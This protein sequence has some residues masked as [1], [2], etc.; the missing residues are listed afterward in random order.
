MDLF[1]AAGIRVYGVSYDAQPLLTK[2][3]TDY[4]IGYDLLSDEGSAVIRE[5]GILNTTIEPDS[6]D[7][8]PQT[9]QTFYGIPF[10]GVY[11]VDEQGVVSDKFFHRHYA[12]RESAGSIRDSA[13]GEILARHEV[14][15][16][17]LSDDHL[18][19]SVFLADED[20]EFETTSTIYVRFELA[21]GFHIY[22]AP[23]PEGYVATTVTLPETKGVRFGEAVYPPTHERDFPE[24]G[25][26]LNVY[27][28]VTDIAIPVALNAEILN[29]T[30]AEKP[31]EIELPLS[32]TY[33]AC[34]ETVCYRPRT[35]T[36]MLNVAIQPLVMPGAPRQGR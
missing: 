9:G 22:G 15:V 7:K 1:E 4:S 10:P 3:A 11:L 36:M 27:E 29:W 31:S 2:F 20:L 32:V 28:G 6:V 26:T 25:V 23:L 24:L 16:T 12:T 33:Q 14:P 19:V 21:E 30:I 35:E 18:R 5:F 8:H 17:E 13:L 34:S